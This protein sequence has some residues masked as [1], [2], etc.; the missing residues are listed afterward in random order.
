LIDLSN[1]AGFPKLISS[2]T[3]ATYNFVKVDRSKYVFCD[4]TGVSR[5]EANTIL[6]A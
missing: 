1:L 5:A 2:P 6:F 4:L 3:S